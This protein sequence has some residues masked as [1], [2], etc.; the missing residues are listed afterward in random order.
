MNF[1]PRS[2]RVVKSLVTPL[3][4]NRRFPSKGNRRPTYLGQYSY[5][6]LEPRRVLTSPVIDVPSANT[7]N[8]IEINHVDNAIEVVVDGTVVGAYNAQIIVTLTVNGNGGNDEFHVN[9]PRLSRVAGAY[10]LVGDGDD[11][12]HVDTWESPKWKFDGGNGVSI[13]VGRIHGDGMVEFHGGSNVD[14]FTFPTSEYGIKVTGG[15]RDDKFIVDENI[16]GNLQLL[17]EA[18]DDS[19][20][21]AISSLSEVTIAD[22]VGSGNDFLFASGTNQSDLIEVD[23]SSISV[24][25]ELFPIENTPNDWGI[26]S[27]GINALDGDD[28]FNI[29]STIEEVRYLGSAGNDRFHI[30]DKTFATSATNLTIDGGAGENE[31][32]V[33]RTAINGNAA[34]SEIV[35]NSGSI[36]GATLAEIRYLATDGTFSFIELSGSTGAA[37]GDDVYDDVF[38]INSFGATSLGRINS[39]GGNDQIY[40]DGYFSSFV[41]IDGG[42]GSDSIE[43]DLEG[44]TFHGFRRTVAIDDSGPSTDIN[45]L[46][47]FFS[48]G[49]DHVTV[50]TTLPGERASH[51][52]GDSVVEYDPSRFDILALDAKTGL[53]TPNTF[54]VTGTHA[55]QLILTS[56][57][58]DS[59]ARDPITNEFNITADFFENGQLFV[60]GSGRN[61]TLTVVGT[62]EADVFEINEHSF[63]VNGN[64]ILPADPADSTISGI[65]DFRASGQD[66]NDVFVV[67]SATRPFS[68]SGG[69][70]DDQFLIHDTAPASSE[71]YEL[72]I[73][74]EKGDNLLDIQKIADTPNSITVDTGIDFYGERDNF[75]GNA[76]KSIIHFESTDGRFGGETGGI[77]I[78][79]LDDVDDAFFILGTIPKDSLKLMGGTGNDYHR[80]E[81]RVRGDVW[82]DAADGHDRYVVF[83]D[84]RNSRNIHVADSGDDGSI[85]RINVYLTDDVEDIVLEGPEV[86]VANDHVTFAPTIETVE[87]L[88]GDGNDRVEVRQFDGVRYLI[89]KGQRG[90]DTLIVNGG[91]GVENI[92]LIG[93]EDNDTFELLD[94]TTPGFVGAYGNHGLDSFI[95]ASEFGSNTHLDGGL[96]DDRF[97]ITFAESGSRY[98]RITDAGQRYGYSATVRA[99]VSESPMVLRANG[100][101]TGR[102]HL[103]TFGKLNVLDILG[104]EGRDYISMYA[105]PAPKI[106]INTYGQSDIFTIN[107]S[108]GALDL[109]ADLGTGNDVANIFSTAP[110]SSVALR[111]GNDDDLVNIGSPS[112]AD[113]G[114]LDRLEGA[115]DIRLGLGTDRLYVNDAQSTGTYGYQL[116]GTVVK[117]DSTI[118]ARRFSGFRYASADVLQ[119]RSTAQPNKFRVSPNPIVR[120]MLDGNS[121]NSNSLS[122][123]GLNDGRLL[124]KTGEFSGIWKFDRFLDI[125]FNQFA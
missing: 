104:T 83:I 96:H 105:A 69:D 54:T 71:I 48:S 93:D 88:M 29:N 85:D 4:S 9:I 46:D 1:K 27:F 34:D 111:T 24:N 84:E 12:L 102:Q 30:T 109:T 7:D 97:D 19:Y 72:M 49:G 81:Q 18:G 125:Q 63:L 20:V 5:H 67:N 59:G 73:D 36:L 32:S 25:G 41:E 76:A 118:E 14:E 68:L 55:K 37:T 110:E 115:L 107:S 78:R 103:V 62:N 89:I 91:L 35:V 13:D 92:Q 22:S 75:I 90:D 17:G 116:T 47:V 114:N 61:N 44:G 94:T 74:G 100:I 33:G 40:V 16:S 124:F 15:D 11:S 77:I 120:F 43:V 66:G 95:I 117:N 99:S 80:V 112:A 123:L 21:V 119:F 50:E 45:R 42:Q 23:E 82:M 60:T 28:I 101:A 2:I 121:L 86:A 79:G 58:S 52:V 53:S 122:V 87:I 31:L 3:K 39:L 56:G 64:V 51:A 10:V 70:G 108:N 6:R 57:Y 26:E 113:N 98:L 8:V 65:S 106:S 38:R